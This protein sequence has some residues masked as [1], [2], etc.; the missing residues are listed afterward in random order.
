MC[1]SAC[2]FRYITNDI[3]ERTVFSPTFEF[4]FP[5]LWVNALRRMHLLYVSYLIDNMQHT[6][7]MAMAMAMDICVRIC[8]ASN[9]TLQ[10]K[11]N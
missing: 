4:T 6:M 3:N 8:V 11:I 1:A 9:Y 5:L 2:A 7:A 10:F